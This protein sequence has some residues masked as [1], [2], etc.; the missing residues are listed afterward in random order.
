VEEA[1]AWL[2]HHILGAGNGVP[3]WAPVNSQI[4]FS[5]QTRTDPESGK[6]VITEPAVREPRPSWAEVTTFTERWH[7][8]GTVSGGPDGALQTEP[9]TGWTRAFTAGQLT[10]ARAVDKLITTGQEEWQGTPKT[11]STGKFDR[12][13]LAVWTTAPL[14]A[15]DGGGTAR[16][17]RGVP[18]LA[19]TVR[20]TAAAATLV[21]Y[22]FDVGPDD[23]A[24]II[25]HEPLTL[26]DLTPGEDRSVSWRLQ[27]AGY[28]V[29]DGHRL[30]LVV[31]SKDQLYSDANTADS[32]TTIASPADSASY[33]QLPLG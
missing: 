7:L 1:F 22:L 9:A 17:I 18:S 25:S 4:M 5:Y 6:V 10:D 29:A 11:Y 16:R 19:L 21:A 31:N 30:M 32:T 8:T 14:A 20:S 2:D 33:L 3:D 24:R 12:Q 13:H 28:D 23:T 27:A 26:L 15:A